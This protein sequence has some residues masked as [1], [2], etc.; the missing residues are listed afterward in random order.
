MHAEVA[1]DPVA[2]AMV[3]VDA[4]LPERGTGKRIDLRTRRPRGKPQGRKRDVSLE[5]AG[6]PIPHLIR[7]R[8][9][10]DRP[11]DV[12]RAVEILGAGIHQ[13]EFAIA[14]RPV[15]PGRDPIVDDR[16]IRPGAGDRIEARV[17]KMLA[18]PTEILELCGRA[19][20]VHP[21]TR[22]RAIEPVEEPREGE[23]VTQVGHACPLEFRR[24]LDRLGPRHRV[25]ATQHLGVGQPVEHPGRCRV[26]AHK[27][28][29]ARQPLERVRECLRHMHPHTVAEMRREL[30]HQLFRGNKPVHARIGMQDREA[31]RQRCVVHIRAAYVEQ[32]GDRI[33]LRQDRGIRA[34]A[35]DYLRDFR[36]L[37]RAVP[38]R[39]TALVRNDRCA[40]RRWPIRPGR[41]EGVLRDRH[42]L[43]ARPVSRPRQPFGL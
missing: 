33:R 3:I 37:V 2:R 24:V 26:G 30:I 19:H 16:A 42:E 1:A 17:A 25:V 27:H 12:R 5:H 10:R 14:Q 13:V 6:K 11:R 18:G 38:A 41:V 43:G 20:L 31:E 29:P 15:R 21:A 7:R 39:E 34:A 28:P 4:R 9:D 8:P 40:R 32:P 35:L 23:R 36:S 22:R